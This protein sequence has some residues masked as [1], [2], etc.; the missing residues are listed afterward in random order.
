MEPTEWEQTYSKLADDEILWS[1]FPEIEDFI[2]FAKKENVVRVLDAGCGD[3][4]NL[5]ALVK[6]QEFFCVGLDSSPS[7]LQVCQREILHRNKQFVT[8]VKMTD[9][10]INRFCLVPAPIEKMPFLDGHFDAA[11]CIDVINHN[12]DPYPIFSELSRVVKKN[13]LIYISFFNIEDEIITDER[14]K[15]NMKPLENGIIGREYLYEFKN[16]NDETIQYYFRFLKFDEVE[17]FIKPTG[18]VVENKKVK[19]WKNPPH[20][21]FRPYEHTHCNIMVLCRNTK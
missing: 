4:K 16:S 9:K 2:P 1:T 13:G 18:L 21:H 3:G 12:P 6:E 20:P 19:F 7:A 11:I 14:Y 8:E 17:D 10:Q 5:C 15:I